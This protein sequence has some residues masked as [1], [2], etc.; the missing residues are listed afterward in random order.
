[1]KSALCFATLFLLMSTPAHAYEVETGS[2]TICDTQKQVERFAQLLDENPEL[3]I[4]AVNAEE[5]NPNAC[6]AVD[7]SYVQGPQIGTARSSSHA[8]QIIPIVVFGVNMPARFQAVK[9]RLFFTL[10]EVKEFAV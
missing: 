8:F 1:M 5:H 6:V 7:V 9:P 4:S 10:V 3:A 2:I